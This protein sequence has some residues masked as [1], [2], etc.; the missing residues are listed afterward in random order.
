MKT[1]LCVFALT[2]ALLAQPNPDT[3]WT[4][5]FGSDMS[6]MVNDAC[7]DPDGAILITGN[8]GYNGDETGPQDMFFYRRDANGNDDW[9]TVIPV[10]QTSEFSYAVCGTANHDVVIAGRD[11]FP[12]DPNFA[13]LIRLN[14]AGEVFNRTYGNPGEHAGFVGVAELSNGDIIAAGTHQLPETSV[15]AYLV[16]VN[17]LG[18]TIWTRSFGD[19]MVEYV[20]DMALTDNGQIVLVGWAVGNGYH[21]QLMG[22]DT[23]GNLLWQRRYDPPPGAE[24][25]W[26]RCIDILPNGDL[27]IGGESDG[28][29]DINLWI[30]RATAAG[31]SLWT[32]Q[33]AFDPYTSEVAGICPGAGGGMVAVACVGSY[34]AYHIT[35]MKTDDDGNLAW[36]WDY[37]PEDYS[38][39]ITGV[40]FLEDTS[41]LIT[42][43][44]FDNASQA[45]VLLIKTGPEIIE[46]AEHPLGCAPS[47]F[48]LSA[49]PNPF[50][51]RTTIRFT[52]PSPGDVNLQVH[53]VSGRLVRALVAENYPGGSHELSFDGSDLP[54][55]VYFL[56]MESGAFSSSHKLLLLK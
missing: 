45:D 49:Y 22:V 28:V 18:D 13:R 17:S 23:D 47:S 55:G 20:S 52:L 14:D 42:G 39:C 1:L 7:V 5:Q 6:D 54:S 32:R 35:L 53:D 43:T 31:D 12:N 9:S 41:Y 46:S 33:F 4:R 21:A 15:D 37:F 38:M 19:E 10:P 29:T 24:W 3:L 34:P 8:C 16:R 27:A 26:A 25:V 11:G 51:P 50:N 40:K 56:S 44:A 2:G 30:M 36:Q 48:V